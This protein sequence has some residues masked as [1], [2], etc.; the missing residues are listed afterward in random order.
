MITLEQLSNG[1]SRYV[2]DLCKVASKPRLTSDFKWVHACTSPRDVFNSPCKF[3]G[4]ATGDNFTCKGCPGS[5]RVHALF[6][7]EIHGSCLPLATV[8]GVACCT[9]CRE[10]EA[11]IPAD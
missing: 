7:C 4:D 6:A 5:P 1:Y 11:K 3:L 8:A 2:C 10:Y 9:N